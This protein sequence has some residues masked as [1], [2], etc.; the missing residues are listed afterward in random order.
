MSCFQPIYAGLA[1][2]DSRPSKLGVMMDLIGEF[3]VKRELDLLSSVS[4]NAHGNVGIKTQEGSI[5]MRTAI[6]T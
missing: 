3:Q 1:T 6:G 2:Y 4:G 5:V